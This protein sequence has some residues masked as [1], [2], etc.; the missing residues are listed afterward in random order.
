MYDKNSKTAS[1]QIIEKEEQ[2]SKSYLGHVIKDKMGPSS[3]SKSLIVRVKFPSS[4]EYRSRV[5]VSPLSFL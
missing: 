3:T 4:A 1:N 5:I 2:R